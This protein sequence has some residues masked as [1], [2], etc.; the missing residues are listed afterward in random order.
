MAQ[1]AEMT[2][3]PA[4]NNGQ[5]TPL[6]QRPIAVQGFGATDRG[7]VRGSNEDQFVVA[8]LTRALWI[9]QSSVPQPNM[10]YADDR[11]HIFVVADGMGGANGGQQASAMAVGTIEGFLLNALKWVVGL[12]GSSDASA[13]RAFQAALRR[14]DADVHQ[15]AAS[16][17]G[18]RGMGT[19]LTM[20]Y[21]IGSDLFV[22]H[23]GDSR[24]Y[25]LRAGE[26]HQ[27]T[28]DHTVVQELLDKGVVSPSEA[29]HHSLRHIITNVV[30]GDAPGVHIE[31]HRLT[32]E[33][34]DVLLLCTDGLTNMLSDGQV[35]ALLD[36]TPTPEEACKELI[37]FANEAGGEDNITAIVAR[38]A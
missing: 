10:Q 28:R 18:L 1:I 34:G 33:R 23:V 19:T 29:A 14:A 17:P 26:L 25:L 21:A 7:K 6:E 30:G 24:C 4:P 31:V 2:G 9:E 37:R 36:A 32:I 22:A 16:D 35:R 5:A 20:A 27:I 12:D 38:C 3:L 15:A 13:L 11:G 8:M